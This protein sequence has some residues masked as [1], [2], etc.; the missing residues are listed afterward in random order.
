M[1][2]ALKRALDLLAA[3]AGLVVLAP[4]LA[5]IAVAIRI[6]MGSPVFFR[7]QRPGLRARP[8]TLLKFRTMT[9]V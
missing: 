7:Q 3:S 9:D 2:R 8:F 1:P 5:A 4:L 6:G